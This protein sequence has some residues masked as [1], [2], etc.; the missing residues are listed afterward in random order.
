MSS[1]DAD[2]LI[3]GGHQDDDRHGRADHAEDPEQDLDE[4]PDRARAERVRQDDPGAGGDV[5]LV[6]RADAVAPGGATLP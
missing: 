1:Q 2:V 5:R 3:V 4:Q 6:D